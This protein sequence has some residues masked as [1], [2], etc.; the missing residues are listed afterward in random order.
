MRGRIAVPDFTFKAIFVP[1]R[2]IA[3]AYVAT[4]TATPVCTIVSIAD[5]TRRA[6][7]DPFPSLSA[8]LKATVP[9]FTLPQGAGVPLPDCH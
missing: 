8:T 5:L 9:A 6:G 4:N 2:G 1:S 3:I 7:V